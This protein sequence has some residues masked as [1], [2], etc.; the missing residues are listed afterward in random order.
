MK[1]YSA[2]HE[3]QE[4]FFAFFFFLGPW[5][6]D[7]PDIP[8][9]PDAPEI[10]NF[11]EIFKSAFEWTIMNLLDASVEAMN[12]IFSV[13]FESYLFY[14]N[15]IEIAAL[16]SIWWTSLGIYVLIVV[17]SL[18]SILLT[19][20]LLAGK[21]DADFQL[22]FER[23]AKWTVFVGLSKPAIALA[24][25]L[26]HTISSLYYTKGFDMRVAAAL[27]ERLIDTMSLFEGLAF[28][29]IGTTLLL[30][31]G[32]AFLVFLIIRML[33][34]YVLFALFPLI[35]GLKL[36]RVGPWKHLQSMASNYIE[37]SVKLML[38]GIIITACLSVTTVVADLDSY[39][40]PDEG[41]FSSAKGVDLGPDQ[42]DGRLASVDKKRAMM[43]VILF[44]IPLVVINTLGY[45]IVLEVV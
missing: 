30:L 45:Q 41:S 13:G 8:D 16:N 26:T 23:A 1:A 43:D 7:P 28:G 38:F 40:S 5:I 27:T 39:S 33:I 4:P 21:D 36:V 9:I 19:G 20:Q 25:S 18:I 35:A 24:V 34:V 37:A 17:L 12:L 29:M 22:F 15:P 11:Y 6:P 44:L 14:R 3:P 42:A 31:L 10:P 32:V 2:H